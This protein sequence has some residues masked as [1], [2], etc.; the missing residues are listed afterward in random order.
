[1]QSMGNNH[2][3]QNNFGASFGGP[4]AH[5]KTFFF[6]NYEGFRHSMADTMIDTVPTQAEI[7]GDFSQSGVNIYDPANGRQQFQ[8]NG[9]LNV[10]DPSRINPAIKTFLQQYV[11]LPN[12]MPGMMMPCGAAA[13]GTPGIV[14]GGT[15]CNNYEDVRNELQVNDQGTVRIDQN[16][17]NGDSMI[18]R[19]S[20]SAETGFT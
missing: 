15:D 1:F 10:I 2:M 11:P 5:N 9:Q 17:S 3:V 20:L 13:M 18:A 16:F 8:Y 7:N 6:V 14:G 19:Y 4:I 12:V